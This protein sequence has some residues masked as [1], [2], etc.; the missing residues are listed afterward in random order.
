[1][2]L[3]LFY[4]RLTKRRRVLLWNPFVQQILNHPPPPRAAT[5]AI[6]SDHHVEDTHFSRIFAIYLL[7]VNSK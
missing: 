7:R 5:D 2:A 4:P 3:T 6:H 1:M